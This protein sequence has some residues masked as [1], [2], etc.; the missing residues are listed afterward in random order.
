MSDNV[1]TK[2]F[3]WVESATRYPPFP[4]DYTRQEL[5]AY[6]K[7]NADDI[8][9][10]I[11][12]FKKFTNFYLWMRYTHP[13]KHELT[14]KTGKGVPAELEPFF[15]IYINEAIRFN[16]AEAVRNQEL[17]GTQG[18]K[19]W[20]EDD[21]KVSEFEHQLCK[22]LHERVMKETI[23]PKDGMPSENEYWYRRLYSNEAFQNDISLAY[24][25]QEYEFRCKRIRELSLQLPQ[26]LQISQLQHAIV[27][28]DSQIATMLYI[29]NRDG[30]HRNVGAEPKSIIKTFPQE[31]IKNMRTCNTKRQDSNGRVRYTV[32]DF[33]FTIHRNGNEE[34]KYLSEFFNDM[35]DLKKRRQIREAIRP[36]YLKDVCKIPEKTMFQK[37]CEQLQQYLNNYV[38]RSEKYGE[39]EKYIIYRIKTYFMSFLWFGASPT[40]II[41]PGADH[42]VG[43]HTVI[44]ELIASM[45]TEFYLRHIDTIGYICRGSYSLDKEI[46][47]ISKQ[48]E[49][50]ES[51]G[52]RRECTFRRQALY[53]S[54]MVQSVCMYEI[55]K[56]SSLRKCLLNQEQMR[57][58][59]KQM[60]KSCIEL[61]GLFNGKPQ[62]W[63][64]EVNFIRL[65]ERYNDVLINYDGSAAF[66][67]TAEEDVKLCS[68]LF[69]CR[70]LDE[71]YREKEATLGA[72]AEL[73]K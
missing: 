34:T 52:S 50:D 38:N 39:I 45:Y 35:K 64:N 14:K 44:D 19:L 49:V 13:D 32:H 4:T 37:A 8:R 58:I 67:F 9:S 3:D 1:K 70:V 61:Y 43:T 71:V 48:F 30:F 33:E 10:Y 69:L 51:K 18:N 55:P 21:D 47:R 41:S 63:M 11:M 57:S 73:K 46:E 5:E 25:E 59:S 60:E 28:M 15:S 12:N 7:V 66:A 42:T 31:L 26:S 53:Y 65:W 24:W 20:L 62:D 68:A 40:G 56:H 36:H 23:M 17:T 72:Y 22:K 54:E 16:E 27:N 29:I 2:T 6:W